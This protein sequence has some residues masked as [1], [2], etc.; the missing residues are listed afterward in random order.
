[1]DKL[2][3]GDLPF[4]DLDD[5]EG[6]HVSWRDLWENPEPI[7]SHLVGTPFDRE[8]HTLLRELNV[9]VD[10]DRVLVDRAVAKR[11]MEK[12]A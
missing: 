5:I 2:G 8:R 10:F 11:Y 9:Q 7:W 4:P 12:F 6:M 1:M 3:F